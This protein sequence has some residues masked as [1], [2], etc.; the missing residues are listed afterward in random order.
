MSMPTVSAPQSA[1]QQRA[2]AAAA[3]VH[4]AIGRGRA[5]KRPQHVVPDL[6]A[7]QRRR[8][9]LVPGVGVQRFV[10][11]P[12][13]LGERLARPEIQKRVALLRIRAAA[14][15]ADQRRQGV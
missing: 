11:V 5:Q 1:F 3:Q 9:A 2:S 13:L 14:A 7:E 8:H 6:R 4:D 15:R 10:E 12:G